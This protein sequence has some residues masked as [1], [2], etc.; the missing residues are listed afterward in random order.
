MGILARPNAEAG[1]PFSVPAVKV[2]HAVR[3]FVLVAMAASDVSFTE[4]ASPV[5]R[6]AFLV[7][8]INAAF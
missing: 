2:L 5:N 8:L 7:I 3:A 6:G 1:K 4:I